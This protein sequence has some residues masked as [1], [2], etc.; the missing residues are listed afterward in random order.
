MC[1]LCPTWP[2]IS[3]ECQEPNR[4][5]ERHWGHEVFCIQSGSMQVLEPLLSLT[6]SSL[7]TTQ[8]PTPNTLCHGVWRPLRTTY[9]QPFSSQNV[10][11]CYCHVIPA[12][13]CRLRFR[14]CRQVPLCS[15]VI[16]VFYNRRHVAP[17]SCHTN[18]IMQTLS[19]EELFQV[20]GPQQS[21]PH[22]SP[23]PLFM[24][25]S[26]DAAD[27]YY[28][29]PIYGLELPCSR[30]PPLLAKRGATVFLNGTSGKLWSISDY[31]KPIHVRL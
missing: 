9:S 25:R 3:I 15:A 5:E 19:S 30:V 2:A 18:T 10:T 14:P 17:L 8:H 31:C 20:E 6:T 12:E 16:R 1:S 4:L 27:C 23:H 22:K 7:G 21:P 13:C 24:Q 29:T 11:T 26:R 28:T